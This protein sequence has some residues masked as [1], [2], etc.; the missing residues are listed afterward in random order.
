M[1]LAAKRNW[2]KEA[3]QFFRHITGKFD[4]DE[5]H[6]AVFYCRLSLRERCKGRHFRGAKG[7]SCFPHDAN[8]AAEHAPYVLYAAGILVFFVA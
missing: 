3:R 6:H 1:K 4:I 2:T 8:A 5:K 7:D